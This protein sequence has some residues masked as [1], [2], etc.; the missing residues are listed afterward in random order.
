MIS[1]H[2]QEE[3]FERPVVLH[4]RPELIQCAARLHLTMI[5]YADAVGQFLGDG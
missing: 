5:N 4:L 3:V 2:L 1:C